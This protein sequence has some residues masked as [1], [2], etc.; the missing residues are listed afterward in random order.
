MEGA[1]IEPTDH[2]GNSLG[3]QKVES[4]TEVKQVD[5]E[6]EQREKMEK[7]KAKAM[8]QVKSQTITTEGGVEL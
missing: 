8:A 7:M 4:N 6:A 2:E 5:E 3:A 1:L